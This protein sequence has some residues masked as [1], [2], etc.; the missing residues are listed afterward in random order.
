[1][2]SSIDKDSEIRRRNASGRNGDD[3]LFVASQPSAS[4]SRGELNSRRFPHHRIVSFG[5]QELDY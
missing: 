1:M 4:V 3:V 2:C 5:T